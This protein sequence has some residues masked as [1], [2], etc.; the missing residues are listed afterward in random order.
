MVGSL[1]PIAW[2]TVM[3]GDGNEV[4]VILPDPINDVEG[5][6]WNDPL[7]KAASERGACFGVSEN[8]LRRL[9]HR[10]QEPETKPVK[11]GFIEVD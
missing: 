6:T 4:N 8:P 10:C 11:M 1:A 9:L 2:A 5:K 3:V 7:A